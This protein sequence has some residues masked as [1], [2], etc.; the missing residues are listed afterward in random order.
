MPDAPRGDEGLV[1]VGRLVYAGGKTSKCFAEG[2]LQI[3]DDIYWMRDW[4]RYGDRNPELPG[5]TRSLTATYF[6]GALH[7]PEN[8]ERTVSGAQAAKAVAGGPAAPK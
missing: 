7:T 4:R 3:A 1:R 8:R 5:Q 6:A 2:F